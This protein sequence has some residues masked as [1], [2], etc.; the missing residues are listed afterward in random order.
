MTRCS[1]Q[2]VTTMNSFGWVTENGVVID[3]NTRVEENLTLPALLRS[4]AEGWF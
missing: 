3:E 1:R 2:A 4:E